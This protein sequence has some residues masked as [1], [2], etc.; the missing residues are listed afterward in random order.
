MYAF[1]PFRHLFQA[2]TANVVLNG[3]V[4]VNTYQMALGSEAKKIKLSELDYARPGNYGASSLSGGGGW[5]H[6]K[7]DNKKEVIQVLQDF[8]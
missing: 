7:S 4:N 6:N 3:L 5:L 8:Y 2:L 1:E